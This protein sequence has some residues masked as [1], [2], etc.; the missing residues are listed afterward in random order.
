VK[1]HLWVTAFIATLAIRLLVVGAC[2]DAATMTSFVAS[3]DPGGA[4][5]ANAQSV[6]AWTTTLSS[7][8]GRG[9]GFFS[10]FTLSSTPWVLFSFPSG[11]VNGSIQA[12]HTFDGGPLGVGQAVLIDWANRAVATGSS[13]GVSL[14]SGGTPAVTL[15]FVGGDADGVYRYDDAGGTGQSTG[16]PFA[17]QTMSTLKFAITGLGTYSASYGASNWSGTYAGAIDGI[18]VFNNAGGNG[19]DVPFNNLAVVPEP[20]SCILAIFSIASLLIVRRARN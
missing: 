6:D 14:M 20:V 9:S 11:G 5:D 10:P 15:K 19:S 17:Y 4:P 13:V 2:A 8:G 7:T 1:R 3:G 12:N 16:A 18:Q